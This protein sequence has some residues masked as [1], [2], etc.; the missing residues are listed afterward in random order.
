MVCFKNSKIKKGSVKFCTK[1]NLVLELKI[2]LVFELNIDLVFMKIYLGFQL[3]SYRKN[4]DQVTMLKN[5]SLWSAT[6]STIA[7][8]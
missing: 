6:C 1:I 8:N 4:S 2:N 5:R 3:L 7:L